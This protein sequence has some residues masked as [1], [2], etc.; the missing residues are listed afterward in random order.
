MTK[1]VSGKRVQ[2]KK[3]DKPVWTFTLN[4]QNLKW[5]GIGIGVVILGYILLATGITEE[6]AL[7]QGK[8]NN[9]LV[10]YVA[11]IVL[12]IGY[13]VIIPYALLKTFKKKDAK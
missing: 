3:K 10:I 5:F 1:Q 12:V 2:T 8:W 7:P 4:N 11:P 6:P 13:C 9:P